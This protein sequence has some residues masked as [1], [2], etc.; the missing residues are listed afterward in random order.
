MTDPDR[1]RT[2]KQ[3]AHF[4]SKIVRQNGFVEDGSPCLTF[5]QGGNHNDI[6]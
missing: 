5:W 2:A 1:T 3:S 4:Y 6:F